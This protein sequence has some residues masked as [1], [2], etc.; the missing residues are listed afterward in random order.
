MQTLLT[1]QANHVTDDKPSSVRAVRAFDRDC[2]YA[3]IVR[4]ADGHEDRT[5]W[6]SEIDAKYEF[7]CLLDH[8]GR[9][10][11]RVTRHAI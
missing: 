10:D 5:Y 8:Y 11:Y 7:S 6:L 3:L 9:A 1:G 2:P 4:W